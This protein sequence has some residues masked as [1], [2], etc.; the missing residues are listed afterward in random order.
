MLSIISITT[1][2]LNKVEDKFV[3]QLTAYI[4]EIECAVPY[5]SIRNLNRSFSFK[6]RRTL[7]FFVLSH[8][9]VLEFHQGFHISQSDVVFCFFDDK[10][11]L[12]TM[13]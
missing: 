13:C 1:G 2:N 12:Y 6:K 10:D 11:K 4:A 3:A 9:R 7:N 8:Y 5:K